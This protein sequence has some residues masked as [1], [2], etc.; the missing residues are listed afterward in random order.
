MQ[1]VLLMLMLFAW[2][3]HAE[4]LDEIINDLNK[5]LNRIEKEKSK[6]VAERSYSTHSVVTPGTN[7]QF[8]K[9]KRAESSIAKLLETITHRKNAVIYSPDYILNIKLYY[10]YN[11]AELLV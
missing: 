11:F 6:A 5:D 7:G 3:A 2:Q 1:K 4:T 10:Q 8:D 9:L